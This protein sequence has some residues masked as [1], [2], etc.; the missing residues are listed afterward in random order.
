MAHHY[1]FIFDRKK[2]KHPDQH[3]QMGAVSHTSAGPLAERDPRERPHADLNYSQ[4]LSLATSPGSIIFL[5]GY[6]G[7]LHDTPWELAVSFLWA[8]SQRHTEWALTGIVL[9]KPNKNVSSYRFPEG[10]AGATSPGLEEKMEGG[11][12]WISGR[13]S[14]W[15]SYLL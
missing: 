12:L 1:L 7:Q 10:F 4:A 8:R 3:I 11:V 13:I 2:T 5:H 15:L 14:G 9:F 6:E